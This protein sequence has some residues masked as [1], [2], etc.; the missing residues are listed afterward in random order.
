MR[1]QQRHLR[2]RHSKHQGNGPGLGDGHNAVGIGR[3]HHIAQVGLL[4]AHAPADG[5]H[6]LGVGK[7]Q[8]GAIQCAL[9]HL[10]RAFELAHQRGLGVELLFGRGIQG[11]QVLVACQIDAGVFQLRRVACQRALGLGGG[12]GK[13]AR[14]N[15]RQ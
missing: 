7:L 1:L 5:R 3:L 2:G 12:G 8:L 15:L 10:D 4:Q 6:H 14:V 11:L 13:G 9:V